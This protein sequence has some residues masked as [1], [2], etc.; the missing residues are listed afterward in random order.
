[1]KSIY[2]TRL[3]VLTAALNARRVQTARN[4]LFI[5]YLDPPPPGYRHPSEQEVAECNAL[6][7]PMLHVCF[8]A[9]PTPKPERRDD[10][11]Q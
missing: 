1:M 6:G 11:N 8:V 10:E 4:I 9:P 2:K 7:I 3:K 5:H